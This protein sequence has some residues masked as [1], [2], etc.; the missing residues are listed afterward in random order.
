MATAQNL[1]TPKRLGKLETKAADVIRMLLDGKSQR[2]V[3]AAFSAS[4]RGVQL[5]I[6]RHEDELKAI[7]AEV[8]NN[9][10]DVWIADAEKRIRGLDDDWRALAAVQEARAADRTYADVPGYSTGRMVHTFKA[11]GSGRDQQIVD[12]FQVDVGV[13][14]ERRALVESAA[15]LLGQMPK[16][17]GDV[18]NDNRV[19]II[20]EV[21]TTI[22]PV[23]LG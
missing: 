15:K 7:R 17:G 10:A 4:L 14:A 22:A 2:D 6:E 9:T 16:Q 3:A 11:V 12:E 13:I 18:Y 19:T 8:A 20:R 21:H 5:F 1:V 23:P